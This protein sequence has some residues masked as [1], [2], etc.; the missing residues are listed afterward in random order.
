MTPS[1]RPVL[2]TVALFALPSAGCKKD[3]PQCRKDSDCR[4]E[5]QETCVDGTCQ[6]CKSDADCVA[7]TPAGEAPWTCAAFRCEGA[8]AEAGEG[9]TS[10]GE[11]G[12]P[13]VQRTDCVGGLACT[14]GVCSRCTEDVECSPVTCNVDSGRCSPEGQCETDDQC[15]MDEVCDGGMCVFSGNMSGEAEGPCDVEAVFFAFDSDVL[16][17]KTAESLTQLAQCA[18]TQERAMIL[19]AHAD[20]RGTEEYNILLTERRGTGVKRFL[21][22]HGVPEDKVQVVAK[23]SLEAAGQD[24]P[25]RAKDRRVQ[26]LWQP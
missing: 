18:A 13:C 2:L 9:V 20:N 5:L 11:E 26:I 6:N 1:L 10:D 12:A 4:A 22:E 7:L 25:S 21:V 15:P 14:A 16:T 3:Y 19:E 23:G 17:P 8:T 24:E